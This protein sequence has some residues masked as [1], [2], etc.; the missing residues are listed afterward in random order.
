MARFK[1]TAHSQHSNWE[2]SKLGSEC[3][4]HVH[5]LAA[6]LVTHHDIVEYSKHEFMELKICNI[7]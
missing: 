5:R 7:R 2:L 4:Q 3:R 1:H 6:A